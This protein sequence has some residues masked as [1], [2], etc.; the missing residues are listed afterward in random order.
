MF[1]QKELHLIAEALDFFISN[2]DIAYHPIADY[3]KAADKVVS[4]QEAE[5]DDECASDT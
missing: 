5:Q 3:E 2:T 4:L 1:T